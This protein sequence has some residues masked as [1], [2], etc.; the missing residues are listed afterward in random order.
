MRDPFEQ[1]IEKHNPIEGVDTGPVF[2]NFSAQW[3][4]PFEE[5]P[6]TRT[7]KAIEKGT[8]IVK[9]SVNFYLAGLGLV[10]LVIILPALLRLFIEF[11]RWAYDWVGTIF[12]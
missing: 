12:H 11:S 2:P 3:L 8:D 6:N 7:G 10:A 4:P 1:S 5:G 9:K